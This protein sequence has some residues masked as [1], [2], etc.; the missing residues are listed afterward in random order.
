MKQRVAFARV[1]LHRPDIVVLD[2]ATSALDAES[3]DEMMQMLTNELNATTI[4]SIAHRPELEQFHNRKIVL[5]R[6]RGGARLVTDIDLTS[7]PR[8]RRLLGAAA[9]PPAAQAPSKPRSRSVKRLAVFLCYWSRAA[10]LSAA[11]PALLQRCSY[12]AGNPAQQRAARG[13]VFLSLT[14]LRLG[15]LGQKFAAVAASLARAGPLIKGQLIA[16]RFYE[17]MRDDMAATST[18]TSSGGHSATKK[19]RQIIAE[20]EVS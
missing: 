12:G 6:R 3:Q 19:Y 13:G 2:E 8:R 1:L 5:E 9:R 15:N 7:K 17:A 16:C 10:L 4:V 20:A 18:C 14:C 11:A